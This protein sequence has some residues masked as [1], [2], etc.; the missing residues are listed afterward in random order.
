[1]TYKTGGKIHSFRI[2]DEQLNYLSNANNYDQYAESYIAGKASGKMC[3]IYQ[4]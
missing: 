4:F 1:M 3:L 2:L